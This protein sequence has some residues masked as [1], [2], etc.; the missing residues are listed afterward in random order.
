MKYLLNRSWLASPRMACGVIALVV[1]V[2]SSPAQAPPAAATRLPPAGISIAESDRNELTAGAA[3]LRRD[4]DAL[5]RELA[6]KPSLAAVLPDVEIFHKAVDWALRYDEFF[7]AKQVA[8]ARTLLQQGHERVK[9][10][11]SGQAPWLQ[12]TGLVVRGY[13]SK[14]DQS[15]QPYGLVVPPGGKSEEGRP[16]RLLVW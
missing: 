9:Q 1:G 12:S 3:E 2:N 5:V 4:I 11:R 10:L 8:F 7:D 15:V 6:R 16:H 13:G 14:L